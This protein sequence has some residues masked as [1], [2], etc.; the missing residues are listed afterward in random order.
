LFTGEIFQVITSPP[1]S[2]WLWLINIPGENLNRFG[3]RVLVTSGETSDSSSS[4]S[5]SGGGGGAGGM[6]S[7]GLA[8]GFWRLAFWEGAAWD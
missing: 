6:G 4:G 8:S 5:G 1:P 7:G 3:A 2:S